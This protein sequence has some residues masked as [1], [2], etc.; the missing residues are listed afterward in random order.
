MPD[1]PEV[2]VE[3]LLEVLAI[4]PLLAVELEVPSHGTLEEL[5]VLG[6]R[7]VETSNLVG[8]HIGGHIQDR[9]GLLA[10]QDNNTGD[11]GVVRG[12]K[13]TNR[14]EEVLA[15]SLPAGHETTDL[16][17]RHE[18]EGELL[19]VLEVDTP[20][21]EAL[22]V[23][24]LVEPLER[25]AGTAGVEVRVLALPLLEVE[26]RLGERVEGVLGLGLL[27][28]KGLLGLLVDL[29]LLGGLLLL[30]SL[31][32]L[33]LGGL[34][35]LLLLGG[36]DELGLLL[37]ELDV[38]VV[39]DGGKLGRLDDGV[40]VTNNVGDLGADR[41]VNEAGEGVGEGSG[42]EDVGDR[43]TL[44]NNVGL[45]EE[46]LVKGLEATNDLVDEGLEDG[47]VVGD[48]AREDL[49]GE[50]KADEDLLVGEVLPLAGLGGLLNVGG[51]EVGV[52]GKRGDCNVSDL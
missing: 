37:D 16:V 46:D 13:D 50:A 26:R 12:A 40:G 45:L 29:L 4:N 49:V 2:R 20:D 17:G 24:V 31:G 38:A 19:V 5:L 22:G 1:T 43:E 30:L 14:A 7:D 9:R 23:E 8:F 25:A 32:L 36:S 3:Q 35:G 6:L 34:G 33:G 44:A 28:D 10:T 41:S 51:D 42:E 21:G 27:G 47:L 18:G 52:G 15:R 48:A 11:D 39:E